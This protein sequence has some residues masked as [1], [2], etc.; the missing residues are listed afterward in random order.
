MPIHNTF[1]LKVMLFFPY[2]CPSIAVYTEHKQ[3]E[4]WRCT[5]YQRSLLSMN[6]CI[7]SMTSSWEVVILNGLRSRLA[8]WKPPEEVHS[9]QFII[10]IIR[11][12]EIERQRDRETERETGRLGMVRYSYR[13]SGI[14]DFFCYIGYRIERSS[15][16]RYGTQLLC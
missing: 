12:R 7:N 2:T 3:E 14:S 9:Y 1:P 11:D 5:Y 8:H 15:D 4:C 6:L 10:I 16:I 13:I